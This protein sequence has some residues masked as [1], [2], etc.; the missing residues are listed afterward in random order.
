MTDLEFAQRCCSGSK[1]AWDEFVDKYAR[2]IYTYIN[3]VLKQNS[4]DLLTPENTKDIFQ[5][6]FLLLSK[7]NFR[8]LG[9][10][11]AR[12][13][14]SLASWLRQITVNLT[15]DF[16][17]KYKPA[18]S[19]D[20]ADEDGFTLEGM[21]ADPGASASQ[22]ANQE[23]RINGLR[24]CIGE[25]ND[26][27]RFIIE[28]NIYRGLGLEELRKLLQVSRGAIDMQKARIIQR[29]KDCF[30]RKGFSLD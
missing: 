27:D 4:P 20:Q 17:R 29:L 13:G 10:F 14:C 5:E 25:L 12:N 6:V 21:L 26:D 8:K 23:E 11:E 2:L 16:L 22:L 28:F 18:V 7:D 15:I 3:A 1:Q 9:S 19:L 24:G 30:K